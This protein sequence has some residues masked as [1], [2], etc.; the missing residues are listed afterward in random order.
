MRR[1][2]FIDSVQIVN[3]EHIIRVIKHGNYDAKIYLSDGEYIIA[4]DRWDFF[5]E[6]AQAEKECENND[7][8][9]LGG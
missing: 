7:Y 5:K 9:G 8:P 2:V 4:R 3:L 6:I 1:F